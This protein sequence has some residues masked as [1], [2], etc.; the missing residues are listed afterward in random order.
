[1]S[2]IAGLDRLHIIA[3]LPREVLFLVQAAGRA[4]LGSQGLGHLAG[5]ESGRALAA[6]ATQRFGEG[7]VA[8]QVAEFGR[9]TAGQKGGM[10]VGIARELLDLPVPV[11]GDARRYAH[12][13]VGE[14]DRGR[15]HLRKRFGSMIPVQRAPGRDRAGYRHRMRGSRRNFTDVAV[16]VP[17][18]FRR[19]RRP[20]RTVKRDRRRA[21]HREQGEAVAADAGHVRLDDTLHGDGGERGIDGVAAGSQH[22]EAGGRGRRMRGADHSVLANRDRSALLREITHRLEPP[23]RFVGRRAQDAD[24]SRSRV[25][26]R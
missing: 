7:G 26:R 9:A 17:P 13:F 14:A 3:V 24:R 2:A 18:G 25:A 21:A 8:E 4:Q 10:A 12:A 1:M 15:K 23:L 16:D 19:A 11:P 20:S 22:L 5:I 6:D